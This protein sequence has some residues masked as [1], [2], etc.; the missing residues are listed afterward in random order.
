LRGLLNQQQRGF[1]LASICLQPLAI[2][3]VALGQMLAQEAGGPLA[4]AGGT[5]LF[6]AV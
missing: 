3:G 2:E 4:E 1:Q 5:G 6:V